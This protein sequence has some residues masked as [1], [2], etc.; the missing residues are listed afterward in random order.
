MM[1]LSSICKSYSATS[2]LRGL[3]LEVKE[4]EFVS[5]RGRSGIGKTT[6]LRIMGLLEPPDKGE[7][8][9][10]GETVEGLTDD[11]KSN[12]RLNHVGFIFQFFN[13][14]SSLT[15]LENVEL[16][17][18]LTGTNRQ[19]RRQ[20]AYELLGYFDLANLAERFP[21][22]LSGGEKQRVAAIR[23]LANDPELILADEPT[24]SIDDENTDLLMNLLSKINLEK[25][26]TIVLT[27]TDLYGKLPTTRD[28]LLKEGYLHETTV[29][30]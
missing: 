21:P 6:L 1:E 2:V 22:T 28:Y 23:A 14:I 26:V 11:E 13:L 19:E 20:R 5:I 24:S 10:F 27:T 25:R 30:R 17:L 4:G 7:I 29:Q 16:P 12:L 18:A 8:R 15:V 3:N 9:F